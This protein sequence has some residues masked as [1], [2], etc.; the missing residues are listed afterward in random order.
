MVI[1]KISLQI[2]SKAIKNSRS[3]RYLINI[4]KK[5][6]TYY[7]PLINLALRSSLNMKSCLH[8][9]LQQINL[10]SDSIY[11]TRKSQKKSDQLGN[12]IYRQYLFSFICLL[13]WEIG[14]SF[15]CRRWYST[16]KLM[17][18]RKKCRKKHIT[19]IQVM[20]FC[21]KYGI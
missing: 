17:K 15:H 14:Y 8:P 2:W 19:F 7:L 11:R 10:D 5:V 20:P 3:Y 16:S 12:Q 21:F 18:T 1:S 9:R 6:H 4:C 13:F